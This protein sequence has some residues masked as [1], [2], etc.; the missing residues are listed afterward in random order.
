LQ[1]SGDKAY[2]EAG[3]DFKSSWFPV[4]YVLTQKDNQTVME[5][6][7]QIAFSH[8]TVKN[9]LRE[10]ESNK[11]VSIK[12]HPKDKRSKCVSLTRKGKNL[13]IRLEPLWEGFSRVLKDVF[14]AGHP[15]MPEILNRIDAALEAE[16]L[17]V[18]L[19]KVLEN[20]VDIRKAD[21]QDY[22]A[23][24][25]L[26]VDVYSH[27]EGFPKPNE[28]PAYYEFLRRVGDLAQQSTTEI[29]A[30]YS[31]NNEILGAVVF[32]GDLQH[33]AAGN[34]AG[35][36]D[37]SGFRLLAVSEK[38]QGKRHRKETDDEVHRAIP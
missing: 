33:Y 14:E 9:I 3:L 37:A 8:I 34:I 4:Y 21:P 13:L 36:K 22:P 28:Q 20:Q 5:I 17:H 19:R 25:K 2:Q 32:F 12:P 31:G 1:I 6:A 15:E 7:G 24:G 23:I 16:P 10:L 38:S 35:I 30:A 29:F 27:L 11:L 18:R 26:M